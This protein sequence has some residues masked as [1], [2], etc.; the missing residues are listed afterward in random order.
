M[1]HQFTKVGLANLFGLGLSVAIFFSCSKPAKVEPEVVVPPAE[2][3]LKDVRYFLEAGDRLDTVIVQLKGVSLQNPTPTLTT[4]PFEGQYDELVK[5]SR[6]E[7]DRSTLPQDVKLDKI[8]VRVPERW[9]PDDTY[10]YFSEP[11]S[12]SS[13]EQQKPYG[14]YKKEVMDIKIPPK[15]KIVIDRQ[16]DAHHLNCSF[17]GIIVNKTTGQ[18]YSLKGKWI[19]ILSYNNLSVSL[20]QSA[21]PE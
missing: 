9:Y 6:F 8:E 11:F 14:V 7:V 16:I 18:R 17:T 1:L 15:S 5:T 12:L 2:Y 19:G 4:Q 10:G 21:L 13:G 20:N 3:E